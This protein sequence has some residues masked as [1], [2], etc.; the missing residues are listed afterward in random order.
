MSYRKLL[1]FVLT[2]AAAPLLF[3][4]EK[5]A[6]GYTFDL[7]AIYL[8][9][10]P[11][12]KIPDGKIDGYF[13][14]PIALGKGY[15][16]IE[17]E[18]NL[19]LLFVGADLVERKS[20]WGSTSLADFP[21]HNSTMSIIKTTQGLLLYDLHGKARLLTNSFQIQRLSDLDVDQLKDGVPQLSA[22]KNI[23][24]GKLRVYAGVQ[25]RDDHYLILD[26]DRLKIIEKGATPSD[27][28]PHP[29]QK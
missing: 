29:A 9:G 27:Q 11:I 7:R 13:E 6:V 25:A 1:V 17:T 4:G 26:V 28:R 18:R 22:W 8:D 16:F 2:L 10:K 15:V 14:G 24:T 20:M 12:F 21:E 5:S 3:S 19:A 23:N